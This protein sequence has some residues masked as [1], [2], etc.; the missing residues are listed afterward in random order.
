MRYLGSM[1]PHFGFR[2]KVIVTCFRPGILTIW[3]WFLH[4]G[5][6]LPTDSGLNFRLVKSKG[7]HL[8]WIFL[9]GKSQLSYCY[10]QNITFLKK[11]LNPNCILA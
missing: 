2:V 8:T 11:I 5:H 10:F 3:Q 6:S 7:E 9:V 1:Y 4:E